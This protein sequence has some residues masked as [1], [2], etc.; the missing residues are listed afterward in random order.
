MTVSTAENSDRETP[1]AGALTALDAVLL[2]RPILAERLCGVSSRDAFDALAERH[3]F[4]T[5][6]IYAHRGLIRREDIERVRGGR[7]ITADEVIAAMVKALR[8][9]GVAPGELS[10][11]EIFERTENPATRRLE[12]R[13]PGPSPMAHPAPHEARHQIERGLT[14]ARVAEIRAAVDLARHL[15]DP[16]APYYSGGSPDYAHLEMAQRRSEIL[17]KTL[18]HLEAWKTP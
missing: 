12:M 15:E 18:R 10:Y 1:G 5:I 2:F 8:R 17:E 13:R 7:K 6:D 4:R 3:R 9:R 11:D 14:L 16:S